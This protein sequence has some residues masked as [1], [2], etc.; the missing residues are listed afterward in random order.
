MKT[1]TQLKEAT[2]AIDLTT[3]PVESTFWK[4]RIEAYEQ[5]GL[6]RQVSLAKLRQRQEIADKMGFEKVTLP[7]MAQMLMGD[8]PTKIKSAE[9]VHH[10]EYFLG[11]ENEPEKPV[12]PAGSFLEAM[13]AGRQFVSRPHIIPKVLSFKG[14]GRKW[15]LQFGA[16]NF[17]KAEIP[18]GVV[19]RLQEIKELALFDCFSV[20]APEELWVQLPPKPIDP[21]VVASMYVGNNNQHDPT[22]L[23]AHYFIA[24]W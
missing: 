23:A 19:L 18:Y 11:Q 3:K 1:I 20:M 10:P 2:D 8:E 6:K 22:D 17:L 13:L 14:E 21:I 16:L 9:S 24:Q 7:E 15:K 12:E 4:D 5:A